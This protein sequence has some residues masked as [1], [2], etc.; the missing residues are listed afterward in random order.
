[1]SPRFLQGCLGWQLK[2]QV[3][4]SCF[5]DRAFAKAASQNDKVSCEARGSK[6]GASC[7]VIKYQ[8]ISYNII[9]CNT[10]SII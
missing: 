8:R 4:S 5:A 7:Q 9:R 3:P 6:S 1:M 2:A 10:I